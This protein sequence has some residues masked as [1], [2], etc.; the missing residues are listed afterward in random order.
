MEETTE[1]EKVE[2]PIE[3]DCSV[4]VLGEISLENENYKQAREDFRHYLEKRKEVLANN[5][6]SSGSLRWKVISLVL[7]GWNLA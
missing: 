1:P 3:K 7:A 4:T 2:E 6:R 5:S